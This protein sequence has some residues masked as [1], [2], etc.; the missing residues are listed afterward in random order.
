MLNIPKA[1]MKRMLRSGIP[2]RGPVKSM[3]AFIYDIHILVRDGF[4]Y[5]IRFLYSEPLFRSQCEDVGAGLWMEK[6]PDIQGRG[7]IIIGKDV[8]LSGKPTIAF[9]RHLQSPPELI[10]GDGTFIAH[11]TVFAIAQSVRIGKNCLIAGGTTIIDNDG[12]PLDPGRR[13]RKDRLLSEEIK[14]V[15]IGDDVWLGGSAV[16]LK[17]VTIGDRAVVASRAVVTKD[18]PPDTVVAGNPARVVKELGK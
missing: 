16:V 12:H 7:R 2:V 11:N 10:V 18:V 13:R 5:V 1:I 3:F 9:S 8:R 17:G 15:V 14:P 4:I 6:L